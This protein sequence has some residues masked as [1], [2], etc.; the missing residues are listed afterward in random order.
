M[1]GKEPEPAPVAMSAEIKFVPID[2]LVISL[3][4]D[5]RSSHLQFGAELEVVPEYSE[6]V[7]NLMP[8]V[9]DVLNTYLRA[10]DERDLESPSAM[11]R[12]RAQMLRRVQI[13]TGEGRVKDILITEFVL[14]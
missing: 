5:A 10:V 7:M 13:V 6:E 14:N 8:R 1:E 4:P 2:K 9:L 3:G 12:L 11:I